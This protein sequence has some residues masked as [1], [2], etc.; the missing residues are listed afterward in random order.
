MKDWSRG[1]A[2][3]G[4]AKVV[5]ELPEGIRVQDADAQL[6][7]EAEAFLELLMAIASIE[8]PVGIKPSGSTIDY[9]VNS[10]RAWEVW[11]QLAANAERAAARIYLG[12]DGV[13]GAVG[14]APGVDISALFGVGTTKIQGDLACECNAIDTGL[15]EPWCALNHGDSSLA[16]SRE[17]EFPDADLDKRTDSYAKRNTAFLR[18]LASYRANG[19]LVSQEL[20]EHLAAEYSVLVPQLPATTETPRAS[21]ALA[22]TD[23]AEARVSQ[24]LP[25]LADERD[26]LMISELGLPKPEEPAA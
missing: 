24:G 23:I 20:V 15:I 22:P 26:M 7:D 17:Y 12:T 9:L 5:G 4:N 1:S 13:L 21:I 14:G 6:T 11:A 25:P 2:S 3:H 19:F 8:A 10:S 18:D 16:P